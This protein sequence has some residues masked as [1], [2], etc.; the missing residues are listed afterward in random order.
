MSQH[1]FTTHTL[2]HQAAFR[3]T[4]HT[5]LTRNTSPVGPNHEQRLKNQPS[6]KSS[7]W[8]Q[9]S[10]SLVKTK[11]SFNVQKGHLSVLICKLWRERRHGSYFVFRRPVWLVEA[12][13][14]DA[15]APVLFPAREVTSHVATASLQC[16]HAA[17]SPSH[18]HSY[19]TVTYQ[20][21]RRVFHISVLFIQCVKARPE[22]ILS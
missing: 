21:C 15:P 13:V 8:T 1:Y 2:N 11:K 18:T 5:L 16:L 17:L 19:A 20:I 14:H 3:Y 7:A 6:R 9:R 22:I 4:K 12:A 10:S